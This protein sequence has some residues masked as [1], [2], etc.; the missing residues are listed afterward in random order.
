MPIPQLGDEVSF[1]KKVLSQLQIDDLDLD[2]DEVERKGQLN[3][4]IGSVFVK[5]SNEEAKKKIMKK[6]NEQC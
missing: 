5:F 6:K 1:V 2:E 3:G 4:K